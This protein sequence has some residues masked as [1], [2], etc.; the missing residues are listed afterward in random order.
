MA[1][2]DVEGKIPRALESLGPIGG[3]E[4]AVVGGGL[5]G[6]AAALDLVDTGQEGTVLEARPTLGGAG[7]DGLLMGPPP[8]AS[9]I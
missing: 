2:I 9:A 3:R 1:A 6:L 4:V 5:A 7:P 8:P